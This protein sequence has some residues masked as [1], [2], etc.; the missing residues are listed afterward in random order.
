MRAKSSQDVPKRRPK[1]QKRRQ[2][3][4]LGRAKKGAKYDGVRPVDAIHD[5]PSG[6]PPGLRTE[7][8]QDG[9]AR[10][11]GRRVP[12]YCDAERISAGVLF[13]DCVAALFKFFN[14]V[15]RLCS[16]SL[17]ILESQSSILL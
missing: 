5:G 6:V 2:E 17:Q 3:A 14:V 8:E 1:A 13:R 10:L 11:L 7:S 12:A 9:P 15:V 4:V 16:S